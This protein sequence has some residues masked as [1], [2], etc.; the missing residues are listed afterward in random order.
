[1]LNKIKTLCLSLL[2]L[3]SFCLGQEHH[4]G[5]GIYQMAADAGAV[6]NYISEIGQGISEI[7][8]ETSGDEEEDR[9]LTLYGIMNKL[10]T[11]QDS[12]TPQMGIN[13]NSHAKDQNSSNNIG[14]T[15]QPHNQETYTVPAPQMKVRTR[16]KKT[17]AHEKH[18]K[19]QA[20]ENLLTTRE[21]L[22]KSAPQPKARKSKTVFDMPR[23]D[24]KEIQVTPSA[25]DNPSPE[26]STSPSVSVRPPVQKNATAKP[27]KPQ[28][29]PSST[30][31]IKYPS[32]DTHANT[33]AFSSAYS[34]P[35][36]PNSAGR[37][38]NQRRDDA[39]NQQKQKNEE[40]RTKKIQSLKNE[41]EVLTSKKQDLKRKKDREDFKTQVDVLPI[42]DVI[43]ITTTLE[44]ETELSAEEQDRFSYL[45]EKLRDTTNYPDLENNAEYHTDRL[46]YRKL[47]DK[48]IEY[49]V[50]IDYC[51]Q[52][53]AEYDNKLIVC[54]QDRFDSMLTSEEIV[55]ENTR[56][57]VTV[58][59]CETSLA[60][61]DA[62]NKNLNNTQNVD[63]KKE[64]AQIKNNLYEAKIK[65]NLGYQNFEQ[66]A[67]QE[68]IEQ[69]RIKQQADLKQI[70]QDFIEL[71]N[72]RPLNATGQEMLN[73]INDLIVSKNVRK[74][75]DHR[76]LI[77]NAK[78]FLTLFALSSKEYHLSE[79]SQ[80]ML[81]DAGLPL[82]IFTQ[83]T[84]NSFEHKSHQQI[85]DL[86]NKS[87]TNVVNFPQEKLVLDCA[88]Y[89]IALA[90]E[91]VTYSRQGEFEKAIALNN[92][93]HAVLDYSVTYINH[94]G[95][96]SNDLRVLSETILNGVF[97][98]SMRIAKGG[99]TGAQRL[100]HSVTHPV[101]TLR[102]MRDGIATLGKAML[103][104]QS[105]KTRADIMAGLDSE[106]DRQ[107]LMEQVF[108]DAQAVSETTHAILGHVKNISAGDA[109]EEV[110]AFVAETLLTAG[111]GKIAG[112]A[113]QVAKVRGLQSLHA[114]KEM[115]KD[116]QALAAFEG[117]VASAVEQFDLAIGNAAHTEAVIA[118]FG[119]KFPVNSAEKTAVLMEAEKQAVKASGASSSSKV[120][121]KAV[122]ETV[123]L[124]RDLDASVG[125]LS[126]LEKAV[127]ILQELP[128]AKELLDKIL[129]FGKPGASAGNL[130]TARGAAYELETA[131]EAIQRGEKIVSLGEKIK[132]K[133]LKTGDV[134]GTF[135]IDIVTTNKLIEC[136]AWDW[137][138]MELKETTDRVG[139]L[140]SSLGILR[141]LAAQEGK[142]LELSFK[143]KLPIDL[144]C[145]LIEN[146]INFIEGQV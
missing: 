55:K 56:L 25:H 131:Y 75:Q 119:I 145:W 126:I 27:S 144:R 57:E 51:Q 43:D 83:K 28:I 61:I 133:N 4:F 3:G 132:L 89:T 54:A 106:E 134:I 35:C 136:K 67:Q 118:E 58:K 110:S 78:Q 140:Q 127:A 49:Q 120:A 103:T 76:T 37:T 64:I 26:T 69:R 72:N 45:Q 73:I 88:T 60:K 129:I 91:S 86:I 105:F 122:G 116:S 15:L 9:I 84:G 111:L 124:I 50:K 98:G 115:I 79:Q 6:V 142:Q 112:A 16:E 74:N 138:R 48:V 20:I 128:G 130:S 53:I 139:K 82:D 141:K 46:N 117:K 19:K 87:A 99:C 31:K 40:L 101:E 104:M 96:C 34:G 59:Q 109:L 94:A 90:H 23:N 17:N 81:T 123:Q 33:P 5:D 85:V 97:D 146:K 135:D 100:W 114:A 38:L 77:A 24:K 107:A 1:M 8:E 102:G 63:Q 14:A 70:Q 93:G 13:L 65:L 80:E 125:N 11:Q 21:V 52:L 108:Q 44:L 2:L 41:Y 30:S 113:S 92:L 36:H 95:M 62:K 143:Y 137:P 71:K 10:S 68:K 7:G 121:A 29:A 66:R 32:T 12:A 47:E 39:K 42:Q 18:V 22:P